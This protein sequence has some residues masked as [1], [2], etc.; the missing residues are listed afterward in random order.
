M[1]RLSHRGICVRDLERSRRFY[2]DALGFADAA[3][4]GVL[5][6]PDMDRTMQLPG[7]EVAAPMLSLPDGPT[8]ELLH[9]RSP[10]A[11]GGGERPPFTGYGLF[12]LA[13]AVA[14][15]DAACA[16][17]TAAGG[18]DLRHTRVRRDDATMQYCTDPDGVRIHL[19][20]RPGGREGFLHSGIRVSDLDACSHFYAALGFTVAAER[21]FTTPTEW[22]ST[23]TETPGLTMRVRFLEDA[24]GNRLELLRVLTPPAAGPRERRPLNRIGPTHLAFWADEPRAVIAA[25]EERGGYFV[26]E[27]HVTTPQV[28]LHHGADP[29]GVRIELMRLTAGP[30]VVGPP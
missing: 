30:D 9:F 28:E 16:R 3:D 18:L 27:A 22:M 11:T 14:D 26:E 15:L 7:V 10:L 1:I 25:L 6:G 5:S 17:I 19:V 29:D 20:C 24:R 12:H 13:F 4:P 2:R 21:D 8:I 23:Q